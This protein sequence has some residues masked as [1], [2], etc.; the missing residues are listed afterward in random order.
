[1][2]LTGALKKNLAAANN[3]WVVSQPQ[4]HTAGKAAVA[5]VPLGVKEQKHTVNAHAHTLVPLS[6][7]QGTGHNLITLQKIPE[8]LQFIAYL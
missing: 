6:L 5:G 7:S 4:T 3:L 2:C 8:M 1:M